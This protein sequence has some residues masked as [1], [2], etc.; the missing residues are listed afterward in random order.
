MCVGP[1]AKRT[2]RGPPLSTARLR[3]GDHRMTRC[4]LAQ[5]R[6]EWKVRVVRP[7]R[8]TLHIFLPINNPLLSY[9]A[10]QFAVTMTHDTGT[11]N[12]VANDTATGP[13]AKT[14]GATPASEAT[15]FV[16]SRIHR[17]SLEYAQRV[18]KRVVQPNVDGWPLERCLTECDA[19]CKSWNTES[20]GLGANERL[21]WS[22]C[23]TTLQNTLR[24]ASASRSLL[25]TARDTI[26]S[27]CQ[28]VKSMA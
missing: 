19:A 3:I 18:F 15:V 8:S 12:M 17:K 24:R 22:A 4:Y 7:V 10:S 23:S 25:V 27:T 21:Q 5:S 1:V 14:V 11:N 16:A 6:P 13:D 9:T 20:V 26:P 2:F 28:H